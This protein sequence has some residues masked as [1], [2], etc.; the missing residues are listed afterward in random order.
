MDTANI[1]QCPEVTVKCFLLSRFQK[2]I[3]QQ[4][5]LGEIPLNLIGGTILKNGQDARSTR[6]EFSCGTGILPVPKQVIEN[7][8]IFPLNL[9]SCTILKNGQDARSTKDE[10]S[11]G[12]GI[13]PVPKQVIEN[14]AIF[15]L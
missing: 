4:E 3:G 2:A 1:S 6:D 12:T 5:T 14:G 13:L 15:P 9:K 7:G 11:C 8:A 10:F